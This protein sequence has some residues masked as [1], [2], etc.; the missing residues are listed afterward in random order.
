MHQISIIYCPP[1]RKWDATS[2]ILK[3]SDFNDGLCGRTIVRF[4]M[5]SVRSNDSACYN[6]IPGYRVTPSTEL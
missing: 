6:H 4:I 5:F 2:I 3:Q 1:R